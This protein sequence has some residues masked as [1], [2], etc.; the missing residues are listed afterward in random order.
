[1]PVLQSIDVKQF[2]ILPKKEYPLGKRITVIAGHNATGKSTL[3]A[4]LAQP[5]GVKDLDIWGRPL[6]TKINSIFKLSQKNDIPGSH[7]Y[8]I[9]TYQKLHKDGDTVQVKS[10]AR[11]DHHT[12]IR[13]VTGKTRGPGEGNI[14]IPVYYLGLKRVFPLG[15]STDPTITKHSLSP[16]ETDFFV[17]WH[18]KILQE[19]DIISPQSCSS[20]KREKNTLGIETTTYDS[21]S[22]SAGQDNIGQILGALISLKRYRSNKG[23]NYKGALFMIDEA[24]ITLHAA[25][26]NALVDLLYTEARLNDIQIIV[27]TH[28]LSFISAVT[29]YHSLGREDCHIWYLQAPYG[30]MQVVIDPD[31]EYITRNIT[32]LINKKRHLGNFKVNIY[33]ED[34]EATLFLK[35]LTGS[36]FSKR[37]NF[38]TGKIGCQQLRGAS[39]IKELSNAIFVLDGDQKPSR[40]DPETLIYLPGETSPE[41]LFHS[42]LDSLPADDRFW[43]ED[44]LKAHFLNRQIAYDAPREAWKGWFQSEKSNW[45]ARG[46]SLLY[47]R[48][49]HDNKEQIETFLLA[50]KKAINVAARK[51]GLPTID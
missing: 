15:E 43:R 5:F 18:K 35:K 47:N 25:S 48:W 45:G 49:A 17:K 33:S 13:F 39:K 22:I 37:L 19:I 24:D 2:R 46:M 12:P 50:L 32:L 40:N 23:K 51:Q 26:Q 14:D 4:M 3:L 41:K 44:Y 27:T 16:D 11:E 42:F 34:D 6:R 29:Q 21:L 1:M 10:F 36:K 28:S 20:E 30:E 31:M 8:F 38:I 7:L 9:K